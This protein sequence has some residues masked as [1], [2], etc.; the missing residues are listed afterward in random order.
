MQ[1]LFL[2]YTN[3]RPYYA[4]HLSCLLMY[5]SSSL[6]THIVFISNANKNSSKNSIS[7]LVHCGQ[8]SQSRREGIL[9]LSPHGLLIIEGEFASINGP[10]PPI[11]RLETHA[12]DQAFIFECVRNRRILTDLSTVVRYHRWI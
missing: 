6:L 10:P 1:M 5:N 3:H 2:A 4:N 12:E 7:C 8:T 11:D 9:R